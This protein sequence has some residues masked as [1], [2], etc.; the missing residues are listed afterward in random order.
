MINS[1]RTDTMESV[2]DEVRVNICF[3]LSSSPLHLC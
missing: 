2:Y 3:V 1:E